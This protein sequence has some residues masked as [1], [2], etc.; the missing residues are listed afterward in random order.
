MYLIQELELKRRPDIYFANDSAE[1]LFVEVTRAKEKNVIV[2]IINR[3]PEQSILEFNTELDRL[4]SII[5]KSDKAC[6]LLVDW[7]LDLIRHHCHRQTAEF[8][9]ITY[10]KLFIPLITRP[11]RIT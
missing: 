1:S 3:Q 5:S 9:D 4:L 6:I 2:G 8:L 11:S 7:N 10:S